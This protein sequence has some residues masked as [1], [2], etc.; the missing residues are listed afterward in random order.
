MYKYYLFDL[1]RTLWDFDKNSH[2]VLTS[3]Y[4]KRSL[5]ENFGIESSE[6]FI[7]KYQETNHLLWSKYELGEISKEYLRVARFND[8]LAHFLEVAKDSNNTSPI[9]HSWSSD[10]IKEFATKFSESYMD[11]MSR[12][13]ELFPNTVKV[14]EHLKAN[15]AKIG[16]VTNG[17]KEVQ[18][19]KLR[20]SE[21]LHFMDAIII[22]EEVGAHKP[23]PIIFKRAL[24]SLCGAEYYNNNRLEVRAEALMIGDDFI[25]DIEGAQIF[26]IDQF[27][28]NPYNKPCDGGPTYMGRDLLDILPLKPKRKG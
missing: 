18:Y 11:D 25:N 3:L 9:A 16:I 6:E 12:E 22:S 10:Q 21:I 7:A 28:F 17:F 23:S 5:N 27:Y 2:N 15:G 14:L 1:D 4:H 20:V 24:E 13:R 19:N 8:P 26:G